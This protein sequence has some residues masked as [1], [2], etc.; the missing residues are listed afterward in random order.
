MA[1]HTTEQRAHIVRGLAAYDS[2]IEIIATFKVTWPDTACTALDVETCDRPKLDS[3]WCEYFD[4]QREKFLDAPTAD[5]RVRIAELNWWYKKARARGAFGEAVRC[6][7][8]IDTMD[9]GPSGGA[10]G[11]AVATITRTIIDPACPSV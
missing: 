10:P 7:E 5:R 8:L 6:L 3:A 1:V 4:E 2:L 11:E 9:T